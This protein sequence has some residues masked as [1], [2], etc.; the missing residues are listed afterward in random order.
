M[1]INTLWELIQLEKLV[2]KAIAGDK[3][4]FDTVIRSVSETIY[5]LAYSYTKNREAA[6]D[7]LQ[8]VIYKALISIKDLKNAQYFNTWI[9]RITINCSI[10]YLKKSKRIVQ[11][12]EKIIENKASYSQNTEEILDLHE[13]LRNLD[14]KYR[15]VIILKYFKDLRLEDISEILKVPLGTVKTNLYRGLRKLKIYIEEGTEID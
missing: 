4:S 12:D 14:D 9:M 3:D 10:N 13:A 15:T 7:I 8:D 1:Y 6:L 2:K 5:K 11:I